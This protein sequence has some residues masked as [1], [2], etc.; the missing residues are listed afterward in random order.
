M[1]A[2]DPGGTKLF[3]PECDKDL[4]KED[5]LVV[6]IRLFTVQDQQ[7][8]A[9]RGGKKPGTLMAKI[10]AEGIVD[11]VQGLYDLVPDPNDPEGKKKIKREIPWDG[12]ETLNRMRIMA[13]R[14]I[15]DE[16]MDLSEASEDDEGN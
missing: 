9:N 15:A 7:R 1:L 5:Q 4:P 16:L 14:Q 12:I 6:V 3:T 8:F 11:I 2:Q 10:L 13:R